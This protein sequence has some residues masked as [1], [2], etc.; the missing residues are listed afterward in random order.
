MRILRKSCAKGA[1]EA[2]GLAVII[3]VFRAFSC[4]P[5][6]FHLGAD[7]VIIEADPERAVWLKEK[8]PGFILVGEKNEVPIK[9]ADLGNSPTHIIRKGASY[10][11][12][13]TVVHR[14]TAGVTGAFAAFRGADEVLLGSF[15]TARA[16][17]GYIGKQD[18][19]LVTLVAMGDRGERP[20]PED[21][22]CA[23]YLEHLLTGK[24][25]DPVRVFLEVVFQPTAQKFISGLKE[26][27]PREDPLFCLQRDLFD[28]VLM[29]ERGRDGLEARA[30][31]GRITGG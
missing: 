1:R 5:L 22:A 23:D 6:F 26:Y 9:G 25:Y 21:E 13:R 4:A 11:R 2:R 10:F 29:V 16:I 28:F 20:A 14:T 19:D 8:N 17:A 7:R 27:L 15:V 18:P 3:D 30:V 31:E 24:S 12:N